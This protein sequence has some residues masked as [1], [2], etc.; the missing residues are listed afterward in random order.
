MWE[1][2]RFV[3][4]ELE[5]DNETIFLTA[6]WN[7]MERCQYMDWFMLLEIARFGDTWFSVWGSKAFDDEITTTSSFVRHSRGGPYCHLSV[8]EC[9]RWWP[10]KK[11]QPKKYLLPWR[12]GNINWLSDRE[13]ITFALR[14]CRRPNGENTLVNYIKLWNHI[15]YLRVDNKMANYSKWWCH[16][17]YFCA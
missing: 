2:E 14:M 11:I 10:N 6:F 8:L 13:N 12:Q 15:V 9:F 5:E 7:Y 16:V 1:L 3:E 17:F 4:S